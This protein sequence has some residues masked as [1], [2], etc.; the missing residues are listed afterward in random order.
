MAKPGN[1]AT[2]LTAAALCVVL[3][4]VAI[5]LGSA[6]SNLQKSVEAQKTALA[7]AKKVE[8]QLDALA[9]GVNQLAQG[10]NANARRIIA[11][12]QQNGVNI[13]TGQ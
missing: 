8:T 4:S 5:D 10:G 3:T 11:V 2:T 1:L 7:N 6:R 13:K 9:K 12:L